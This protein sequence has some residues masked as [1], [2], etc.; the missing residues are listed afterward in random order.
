MCEEGK[1]EARRRNA[2]GEALQR[3]KTVTSAALNGSLGRT[4]VCIQCRNDELLTKAA[5]NRRGS[6]I[7]KEV[8]QDSRGGREKT[9]GPREE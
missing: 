4:R 2:V 5:E 9:K 3:K 7:L 8:A 6:G 1:T